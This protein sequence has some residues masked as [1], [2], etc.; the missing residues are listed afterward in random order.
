MAQHTEQPHTLSSYDEE[1]ARIRDFVRTEGD[2]AQQQVLSAV[3]AMQRRDLDHALRIVMADAAIDQLQSQA[4]QDAILTIC[5]RAPMADDLREIIAAIKIAGELERVGDYAKNIAKRVPIIAET[6]TIEPAVIIPEI[7]DFVSDMVG[8][9]VGAYLDRDADRAVS[10]I[11]RDAT[12]DHFY[13]SLFRSLLVHMIENPKHTTQSVHLLFVAK[14]L[15]RVGDHA[16]NV[17][18]MAYYLATGTVI[19]ARPQPLDSIYTSS[20]AA[21]GDLPT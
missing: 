2:L 9:A 19:G 5:R 6:P 18:E 8:D 17:A 20:T 12:V 4:E 7:A 13:N 21:S 1:L 15:E 11:E 14:N 10:V 3:E 16:T